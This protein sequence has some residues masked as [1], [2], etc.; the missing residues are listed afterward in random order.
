MLLMGD[1]YGH[2]KEG[3]NNTWGHD[4]RLNW[5]QWD[6]LE[7]NQELFEFC[8]QMIALR[9]EYAIL[10]RATFLREQDIKWHGVE[11]KKPD[12][13]SH[14]RML[15]YT[16]KDK[17][18]HRTLY[19]AFNAHYEHLEVHLPPKKKKWHRLVDTTYPEISLDGVELNSP[20]YH[21]TP[22]SAIIL[23]TRSSG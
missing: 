5:F 15:A 20:I 9:K 13:G 8:S 17:I 7:K 6:T 19:I 18:N 1:E 23:V 4:S 14:S 3:N 16:L 22:H 21:M 10:R 11:P 2:S 12:W